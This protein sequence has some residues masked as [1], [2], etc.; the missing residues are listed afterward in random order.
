MKSL[1]KNP[2]NRYQTAGEM[3]TDLLRALAD[4]PVAAEAVMTDAERTQFIARPAAALPP[5]FLP[6]RQEFAEEEPERRTGWVWAAII[7]A[8]LLVIGA[9]AYLIY[10]LGSNDTTSSDVAV[11]NV[12]GSPLDTARQQMRQANLLFQPYRTPNGELSATTGGPCDDGS[13]PTTEGVV[14]K[15]LDD[16]GGKV[17]VGQQLTPKSTVF[18]QTFKQSVRNVPDVRGMPF[19]DAQSYLN[20]LGFTDV[21]RASKDVNSATYDAGQVAKQVPA[22]NATAKPDTKIVL[23]LASGK[24]ILPDVRKMSDDAAR[25]LL[26]QRGF[27]NIDDT[28]TK[29]TAISSRDGKV[30]KESPTP[31]LAYKPGQKI[32]L[33]I[34][35]YVPRPVCS[36]VVTTPA[37]TPTTIVV[38]PSPSS[39][40]V[41]PGQGGTPPGQVST[42]PPAPSTVVSTPPARPSSYT[43]CTTPSG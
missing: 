17:S 25:G 19:G 18:Y 30:A 42:T 40:H 16:N 34:W 6:P 26:N 27:T 24:V 29:R 28:Q 2:H 37:P 20:N 3:R 11:P 22:P 8:L 43:V 31:G 41:P 35:N 39:S 7:V 33:V 4:Q 36:T 13:T 12:I 14:C 32:T 21:S 5:P 38:T 1:A 15:L 10:R 23:Y 9:A